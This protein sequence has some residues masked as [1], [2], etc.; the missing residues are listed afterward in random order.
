MVVPVASR[1]YDGTCAAGTL[2]GKVETGYDGGTPGST[3]QALTAGL[4]TQERSY[5]TATAYTTSKAEYD[6]H[7]R[8]VKAWMPNDLANS[9]PTVA[10]AYGTDGAAW[11]TTVTRALGATST[12]WTERGHGNTVKVQGATPT[13]W[14]HYKYDALGLMTAR[15]APTQWGQAATPSLATNIPT[16]MYRYDIY[17]N[18]PTLRSTPAVITTAPLVGDTGTSFPASSL[19][20]TTRRTMTFLDGFGRSIEQQAVSRSGPGA[21]RTVTA[22]RYNALGQVDWESAPFSSMGS[23]RVLSAAGATMLVNPTLVSLV[24]ATD[25]TYDTLGRTIATTSLTLGA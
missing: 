14:T 24:T 20:G 7:G 22:T 6:S 13:D 19:T 1:S 18:G 15:W 5:T 11:K 16:V 25:Y 10:W 17:A 12:T 9:T 8:I 4:V 21:T 23:M 2:T 3:S